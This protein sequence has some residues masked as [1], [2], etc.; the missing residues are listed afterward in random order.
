MIVTIFERQIQ[1]EQS[2]PDRSSLKVKSDDTSEKTRKLS[3]VL[4]HELNIQNHIKV[5]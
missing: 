4:V 3:I 5:M 1:T 2:S